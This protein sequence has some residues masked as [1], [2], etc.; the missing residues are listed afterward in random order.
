MIGIGIIVGS[1]RPGRNGGQVAGWVR[2]VATWHAG[3]EAVFDVLDL[4]EFGLPLLD[5]LVPALV[6]PA[7]NAHTVRWA[8]RA[9]SC[10]GYIFVT[11]EYNGGAPASPQNAIG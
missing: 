3:D 6:A 11:P 5:E 4:K 2:E 9:G 8:Q 1:I 7:S 10:G